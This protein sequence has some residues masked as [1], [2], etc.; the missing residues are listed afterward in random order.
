MFER[1]TEK[2]RS[3]VV[4]AGEEMHERHGTCATTLDM[5]R[6][7]AAMEEGIA[8]LVLAELGVDAQA[9]R[10]RG[11][12]TE[13]EASEESEF[14]DMP[15]K[16]HVPFTKSATGSM[17]KALR[18]ALSMG[19]NYVGTE[20]LLL[21]LVRQDGSSARAWIELT[22]DGG[23]EAVR[24]AVIRHLTGRASRTDEAEAAARDA[25]ERATLAAAEAGRMEA[26]VICLGAVAIE[27]REEADA[28]IEANAIMRRHVGTE[29]E[30]AERLATIAMTKR[31]AADAIEKVLR[32]A[33]GR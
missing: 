27:L 33:E 22:V 23:V 13:T 15:N 6:A 25:D 26:A 20:H 16:G 1:F 29:W 21:G 9:V 31:Q 5:L 12:L 4:K 8:P 2:A 30:A 17:E 3:A 14:V 19:H 11:D 24:D 32:R 10:E 28:L 7:L 18:E